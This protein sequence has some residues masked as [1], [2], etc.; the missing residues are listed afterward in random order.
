MVGTW[1][2]ILEK[3]TELTYLDLGKIISEKIGTHFDEATIRLRRQQGIVW[4]HLSEEHAKQVEDI[5]NGGG[6]PCRI[7]QQDRVI[8]LGEVS[9]HRKGH[10]IENGLEFEDL[11]GKKTLINRDQVVL[12]QVGW[13]SKMVE[14]GQGIPGLIRSDSGLFSSFQGMYRLSNL[15]SAKLPED[16]IGWV[17]HIYQH[18]EQPDFARV[19][20]QSFEYK[21]P[22]EI[23]GG[24]VVHFAAFISDLANALGDNL[25][26]DSYKLAMNAPRKPSEEATFETIDDMQDRAK[27]ELTL[28]RI[29]P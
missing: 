11:Y 22:P 25:L 4:D 12:A 21:Y 24:W 20:G 29:H 23:E 18:G 8:H 19:Y 2:V 28:K 27:W 26:D 10:V 3:Y 13:I 14:S 9:I 7:I 16:P 15:T 1:A 17:L 6:F 5:I